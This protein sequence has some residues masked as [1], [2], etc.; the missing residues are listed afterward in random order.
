MQAVP[1]RVD[2]EIV[3]DADCRGAISPRARIARC[4]RAIVTI[5]RSVDRPGTRGRFR[6]LL[7]RPET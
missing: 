4:T 1:V 3:E 2:R 5:A 6:P 7:E